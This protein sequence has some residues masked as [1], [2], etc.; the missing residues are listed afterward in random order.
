MESVQQR[1]QQGELPEWVQ[2]RDGVEFCSL[3][4]KNLTEGHI[5]SAK[6]QKR[7]AYVHQYGGLEALGA[8]PDAA[9]M[10]EG[11]LVAAGSLPA[12]WGNPAFY[13][14]KPESACL[15]C[16]L[17]HKNADESHVYSEKHLRRTMDPTAHHFEEITT[18]AEVFGVPPPPP[19]P[20][21]Q[22][23][24]L[25]RNPREQE[26]RAQRV[27]PWPLPGS[28][29]LLAIEASLDAKER[30]VVQSLPVDDA[31]QGSASGLCAPLEEVQSPCAQGARPLLA[32]AAR[33][34][35]ESDACEKARVSLA[36]I[37][38]PA[39]S[40]ASARWMRYHS[41]KHGRDFFH[42][43]DTGES[44]WGLPPNVAYCEEF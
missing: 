14:W 19:P 31:P 35:S 1:K 36:S 42:C 27:P 33:A 21:T 34:D 24:G 16:K 7:L 23:W 40:I 30:G 29:A 39:G 43:N 4:Q 8:L 17:C 2:V 20:A 32:E 5:L 13:E 38:Q 11:A 10:G 15:W 18:N 44:V 41:S 26:H 22:M 3:C 25:P 6:H 37:E 28:A 9:G 12:A